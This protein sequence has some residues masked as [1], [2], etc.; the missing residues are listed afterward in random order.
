VTDYNQMLREEINRI[1][2]PSLREMVLTGRRPPDLPEEKLP[3][4]G[5]S[6]RLSEVTPDS[7][8]LQLAT[9]VTEKIDESTK[10]IVHELDQLI[11]EIQAIKQQVMVDADWVKRAVQGHLELGAEALGF[12]TKVRQRLNNL[13]RPAANEYPREASGTA[14]KAPSGPL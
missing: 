12:T 8:A 14:R 5:R 11:E 1:E 2:P 4:V 10:Y 9:K 6:A 13:H 3:G 7:G